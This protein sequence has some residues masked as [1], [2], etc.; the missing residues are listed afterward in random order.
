MNLRPIGW[1]RALR[2]LREGNQPMLLTGLGLVLFQW[3]RS[4]KP[5]KELIYRKEIPLGSTVVV[6]HVRRGA[7]RVEIH[8]PEEPNQQQ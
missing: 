5:S 4:S 6:R 7:P 3:L 8:Q 1:A 2:G